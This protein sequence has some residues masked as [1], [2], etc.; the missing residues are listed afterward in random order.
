M[1]AS[2]YDVLT[3]R[4]YVVIHNQ[5]DRLPTTDTESEPVCHPKSS[6]QIH[7]FPRVK[8]PLYQK[9]KGLNYQ[10]PPDVKDVAN[11]YRQIFHRKKL[12]NVLQ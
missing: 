12:T 5:T 8:K 2:I 1:Q 9:W 4:E 3:F 6:L 11:W 10:S 7:T